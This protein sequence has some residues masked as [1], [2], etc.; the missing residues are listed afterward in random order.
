MSSG[1]REIGRL[2]VGFWLM[3]VTLPDPSVAATSE[4]LHLAL[5]LTAGDVSAH[6]LLTVSA[7]AS[8]QCQVS[9]ENALADA[10]A[11]EILLSN[12]LASDGGVGDFDWPCAGNEGVGRPDAT[13]FQL[14]LEVPAGSQSLR[15]RAGFSTT[16]TETRAT[17]VDEATVFVDWPDRASIEVDLSES[18]RV[19]DSLTP[20]RSLAVDVAGVDSIDLSFR[21]E[22]NVD[23][24]DD[25]AL[26]LADFFFSDDP[27]PEDVTSLGAEDERLPPASF[28]H[29]QALLRV[30]GRGIPLDFTIHY[31]ARNL[32]TRYFFRKWTHSYEWS[33][34]E[35]EDDLGNEELVVLTGDGGSLTFCESPGQSDRFFECNDSQNAS[36]E[37]LSEG[38]SGSLVRNAGVPYRYVDRNQLAYEFDSAGV[39][40]RIAD[41]NGNSLVFTHSQNAYGLYYLDRIVDTRGGTLQL[42]YT[43]D[44]TDFRRRA[45]VSMEYLDESGTTR[46]FLSTTYTL[47][48][49]C[50]NRSTLDLTFV[51]GLE[52]RTEYGYDCQGNIL[53]IQDP[54]GTLVT[55]NAY[56]GDRLIESTNGDGSTRAYDYFQGLMVSTDG[57]GADSI[58]RY[59]AQDQL[60]EK[61]N[62]L[63]HSWRYE[64]DQG[65]QPVATTDPLGNRSQMAYDGRGNLISSVDPL[66]ATSRYTYSDENRIVTSTDPLGREATYTYDTAGNLVLETDPNG[67][68]ISRLYDASGLVVEET[69]R[70]GRATRFAYDPLSGDIRRRTD[71]LG[72]SVEFESDWRGR[73]TAR[74]DERGHRERFEFDQADNLIAVERPDSSVLRY[75]YDSQGRKLE[76]RSPR[77]AV[78][79]F[80][81]TASG[82]LAELTDPL[83]AVTR[84]AYDRED[85]LIEREDP[86]GIRS[87]FEYDEVGHMVQAAAP[88]G[89]TISAEYDASG[90]RTAVIAPLGGRRTY[91]RDALGRVVRE[92][93]PLGRATLNEYDAAGQLTRTTNARGQEIR[94]AYDPAGRLIRVETPSAAWT[95]RYDAN[96]NIL[97]TTEDS[98]ETTVSSFDALDRRTSRTDENG[99]TVSYECDA[100]GNLTALIYPD[101]DRVEYEYDE[102]D[103]LV[104]VLDWA[105]SETTYTY[106]SD[107]NLVEESLPDGSRV[108]YDYDL[109]GQLLEKLDRSADGSI[110]FDVYHVYDAR[111]LPV[112]EDI[113]VT[114]LAVSPPLESL[115]LTYDVADQIA[116]VNDAP[117]EYD[118]DGNL[119]AL[120]L[121]GGTRVFT[122]DE[123]NQ[124]VGVDSD[125]NEYDADGLR[126]STTRGGRV[127]HFV[128]DVGFRRQR[129]LEERDGNGDLIA[130][131]V[132]GRGLISRHDSSGNVQTYHFDSRGSTVALT[133]ETGGITDR[134]AYDSYGRRL[135]H[136]G[137]T[138]QPFTYG[139]RESVVDDDN[140]LYFMK[141]RDYDSNLMRFLQRD[142]DP[143]MSMLDPATLN[144]YAY[145]RGNPVLYLDSDGEFV[146]S[147]IAIGFAVGVGSEVLFDIAFGEFTPGQDNLLDYARSNAVDL[148]VAGI[149]GTIGP[150][151]H[152]RKLVKMG[153]RIKQANRYIRSKTLMRVKPIRAWVASTRKQAYRHAKGALSATWKTFRKGILREVTKNFAFSYAERQIFAEY[154]IEGYKQIAEGWD[155]VAFALADDSVGFYEDVIEGT[156]FDRKIV[157][158]LADFFEDLF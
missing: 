97:E 119:T 108:D 110:L 76:N 15:F 85:R 6:S 41:P 99:Y 64:Y 55:R 63:G 11:G 35:Q 39:L 8:G 17:V 92:T 51:D 74:V 136:R 83:G 27:A 142:P 67:L 78:T 10:D 135:A 1:L 30:P 115:R 120:P 132:H 133:S 31:N 57:E 14:T 94:N 18:A 3:V 128:W 95:H 90:R 65:G 22:D 89:E 114:P 47:T 112:R 70:M 20:W 100:A 158:P 103:R 104:R 71:A 105:G 157:K 131:Y 40:Q 49:D 124:L 4:E 5:G 73:I 21:I 36:F 29:A 72:N 109:A 134:Y 123:T 77:G 88:T 37:S 46:A 154:G 151:S 144:L 118:A 102:L 50:F 93:D 66:G 137:S 107:G 149:L 113:V 23:G 150:A 81:Y 82:K 9:T 56:A 141:A 60:I 117:V 143:R 26:R 145:A 54:D 111:G 139:G 12:G 91:A 148:A 19:R 16:E 146:L 101:G 61:T 87:S 147:A 33:L 140:G 68:S 153:G 25:S 129:L 106:D 52:G 13:Q 24:S 2:V 75:R 43:T 126:V 38:R 127:R 32:R 156:F 122:Y 62:P 79:R 125:R 44:P 69:D 138:E 42:Y 155:D 98:G 130:R 58:Q 80:A 7:T 48:T 96:G 116:T 28:R 34:R 152:A 53:W 59:D 121:N 84:F 86:L 45:L